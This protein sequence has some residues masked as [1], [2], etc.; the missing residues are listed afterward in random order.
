MTAAIANALTGSLE[1]PP[2]A[3]RKQFVVFP[4]SVA[5]DPVGLDAY[6]DAGERTDRMPAG[7]LSMAVLGLFGEVGTLG[8]VLKKKRRDAAAYASYR[9]ALSEDLGDVLWYLS[10]L[11]SRT[12]L[13]LSDIASAA[14]RL[15]NP[16]VDLPCPFTFA[17]LQSVLQHASADSIVDRMVDLATA[18]GA[19]VG[20]LKTRDRTA[21]SKESMREHLVAILAAVIS[22]ANGVEVSLDRAARQN[23]EKIFSRWPVEHRYSSMTDEN[24]PRNEQLPRYFELFIEE[25]SVNNKTYVVQKRNNVIIGDRLTDNKAEK[26]DYRFH[27][28]FHIAYAVHLGWS[29]VLRSLMR[30]KRKSRPDLDENEDGARAIL[31]EEGIATFIFGRASERHF[32]E[33]LD[34]LDYDLL[35][36]VSDFVRGFEAEACSLWQ[37]ERAI[38]DGFKIFRALKSSRK[39]Y[40]KAD[41][42]AHTLTF[43]PS[44]ERLATSRV[45]G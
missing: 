20:E 21:T 5:S 16:A 39:G 18:S 11:A 14:G 34:R 8:C 45:E 7:D 37:W 2:I 15:S 19:L 31:I 23:L 42:L 38:L 6:Q 41:L 12:N 29:P 4:S 24:M 26:D 3:R 22:V 43:E 9:A 1:G 27:D 30:L 35:K 17:D 13:R 40:V 25:H 32:F 28:V 10:A 36:L 44:D 33:G